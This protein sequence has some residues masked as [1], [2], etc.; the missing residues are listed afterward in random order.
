MKSSPTLALHQVS[1][2]PKPG[3]K[4]GHQ[5]LILS[6]DTARTCRACYGSHEPRSPR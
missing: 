6:D 4:F 1:L 5:I 2:P 3:A